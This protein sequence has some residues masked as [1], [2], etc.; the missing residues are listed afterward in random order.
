VLVPIIDVSCT[1]AREYVF[2]HRCVRGVLGAVRTTPVCA[3]LAEVGLE[4]VEYE[5]DEAVEKW[6]VRLFRRGMGERFGIG[7]KE[8]MEETGVWR[9]GWEGRVVRGAMKNRLEGEVW[10]VEVERG[11]CLD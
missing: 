8:E 5:L 2:V 1:S 11:G 4:G 6:G 9:M 3:L 7:W 10:D